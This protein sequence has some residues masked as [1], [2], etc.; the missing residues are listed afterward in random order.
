[1]AALVP[2]GGRASDPEQDVGDVG[3]FF[4]AV[5][6]GVKLEHVFEGCVVV[7]WGLVVGEGEVEKMGDE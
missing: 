5:G 6:S 1:M 3:G 7:V 4:T 2:R